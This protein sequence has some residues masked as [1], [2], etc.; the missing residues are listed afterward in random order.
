MKKFLALLTCG[1]MLALS[2]RAVTISDVASYAVPGLVDE[3]NTSIGQIETQLNSDDT[4]LIT[5]TNRAQVAEGALSTRIVTETNRAIVAEA[6]LAPT[7]ALVTETNRAQVAE[8]VLTTAVVTETNRAQVAEGVLTTAVV[9]ET[10]RAQVAEALLAAKSSLIGSITVGIA[11]NANGGT[12]VASITAY[13]Q[14]GTK[15]VGYHAIKFWI[16]DSEYGAPAAVVGDV[17]ISGTGAAELEQVIDKAEYVIQ[18]SNGVAVVTITD[19]PGGTNYIHTVT[20]GGVISAGT[21]SAFN[22]P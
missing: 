20:A 6:L 12:N 2:A 3:I 7:T 5:E 11:T 18:T 4:A 9:T 16:A 1:V 17:V 15:A 19:T 21:V 8:G 13:T 14:D 22:L 10:N